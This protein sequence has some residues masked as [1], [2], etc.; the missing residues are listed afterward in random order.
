[1]TIDDEDFEFLL[2][3]MLDQVAQ[4][5]YIKEEEVLDSMAISAHAI[6]IKL[7]AKYKKCKIISEYG[8]RIIAKII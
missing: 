4:D 8:R 2:D 6:A 7:L 5:C 1:M 3:T